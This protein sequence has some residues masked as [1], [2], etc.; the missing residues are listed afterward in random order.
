MHLPRS[1][2]SRRRRVGSKGV[3]TIPTRSRR[4][5]P[6]DGPPPRGGRG[7][8]NMFQKRVREVHRASDTVRQLRQE[9]YFPWVLEDFETSENWE[10]TRTADPRGTE[11]LKAWLD[12]VDKHE[13]KAPPREG[14]KLEEDSDKPTGKGYAPWIGRMEGEQNRSSHHVFFILDHKGSGAFKVVPVK[15]S[16]KFTQRPK[17]AVLTSDQAEEAV[18]RQRSG[19]SHR[20]RLT[21]SFTAV[22]Q[23]AEEQR[24]A[25][26]GACSG[27]EGAARLGGW[28]GPRLRRV[29]TWRQQ[30]RGG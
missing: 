3:L 10:S 8:G 6:K 7:K 17:H 25:H 4:T 12:Y 24:V 29:H 1:S 20:I 22:C 21:L 23:A 11:A 18:S 27:Q 14:A 9:E 15:K 2:R 30:Q 19:P 26:A 5:K 13:G 28:V 16:Y